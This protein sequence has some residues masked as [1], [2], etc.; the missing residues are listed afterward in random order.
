MIET[1]LVY[2]RKADE[3]NEFV[4]CGT[5]VEG[6]YI[7]TCRHVWRDADGEKNGGVV[8]EFPRTL[9]EAGTAENASASLA[10]ACDHQ[11]PL[12]D[13]ILLSVT[14]LPTGVMALTVA[15]E[16]RFETGT[17]R[18]HA[19]IPSRSRDVFVDG[20]IKSGTVADGLR[21]ISGDA[22]PAYW[23]EKGSGGSPAFI[24]DGMQLA[25]ILRL[26]ET[27]DPPI[28]EAFILPGSTI[29]RYLERLQMAQAAAKMGVNISILEQAI[30]GLDL[31]DTPLPEIPA[32]IAAAVAAITAKAAEAPASSNAGA[33]IDA[34]RAEAAAKLDGMD[35]D[36]ALTVWDKLLEQDRVELESLTRRKI[37]MLNEKASIHILRHKYSDALITLRKIIQLDPDDSASLDLIGDVR[38]VRDD[39]EGALKA[40]EEGL[41]IRRRLMAADPSR[42]E[43]PRDVLVRPIQIGDL[44]SHR[45]DLQGAL[46]DYREGLEIRRGFTAVEPAARN[47]PTP[48][49]SALTG[50]AT[51]A[52]SAMT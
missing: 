44:H 14:T 39:L 38:R 43:R 30:P 24:G 36:G 5:L 11:K 17:A 25:G 8:V 33:D 7:A 4:G 47:A 45:N 2:I 6:P 19:F 27:G 51:C 34:A 3:T 49:L 13:L 15:P 20:V 31:T 42:A 40:Y 10:D 9:D 41:V 35:T 16:E 23:T 22:S 12:P 48:F 18:I 1:A 50:S 26:S 21:Q 32:K 28:R 29:R 46:K 52:V 37:A